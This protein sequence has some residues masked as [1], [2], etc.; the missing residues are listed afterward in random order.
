[1][2]PLK[3]RTVDSLFMIV[4]ST[5]S[6]HGYDAKSPCRSA[7]TP[8]DT[9]QTEAISFCEESH[10]ARS[11]VN[12][13]DRTLDTR[14]FASRELLNSVWGGS[15]SSIL[16]QSISCQMAE[17]PDKPPTDNH[18]GGY[19]PRR[20][21]APGTCCAMRREPRREASPIRGGALMGHQTHS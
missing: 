3:R 15:L 10:G 1:M 11:G 12:L 20:A 5:V 19:C 13:Q 16:L 21:G 8:T 18:F 6:L 2:A 7:G 4:P 17:V 14:T 9:N